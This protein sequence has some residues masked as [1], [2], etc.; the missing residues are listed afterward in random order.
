MGTLRVAAPPVIIALI[1]PPEPPEQLDG[2]PPLITPRGRAAATAPSEQAERMQGQ[3]RDAPMRVP[4]PDCADYGTG[5]ETA[6]ER[7]KSAIVGQASP[8]AGRHFSSCRSGPSASVKEGRAS[9]I[10]DQHRTSTE[11]GVT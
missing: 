1:P 4:D 3:D 2:K 11:D 9:S 6:V 5:T 8:G 7:N 10:A